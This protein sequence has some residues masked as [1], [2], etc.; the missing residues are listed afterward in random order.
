MHETSELNVS[1]D[2]L[3][4]FL[5]ETIEGI[6]FYYKRYKEVL[7]GHK[8]PE[9]IMGSSTLQSLLI[10]RILRFLYKNLDEDKYEILTN[11]AGLHLGLKNNLALDIAIFEF[12]TLSQEPLDDTYTQVIPLIVIEVDNKIEAENFSDSADYY[13]LKTQK[14]L[15]AGV[16]KVIWITHKVPK[17]TLATP[18]QDWIT[19]NWNKEIELLPD[20]R[21]SVNGLLNAWKISS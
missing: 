2:I 12:A 20:I 14:L 18:Q 17:V 6:P 16:E 4:T 8:T 9:E 15:D 1:Q 3:D 5:Y 10:S 19:S 21:F 11:E 7:R 13:Y